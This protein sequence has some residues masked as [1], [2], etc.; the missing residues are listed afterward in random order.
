MESYSLFTDYDI[1]LFKEGNHFRGYTKF[2][3][4][5]LTV[6]GVS[7]VQFAVWA[8]N[9]REVSVIGNFNGW[10]AHSH[11]LIRRKDDS[12]IWEG[13][14]PGIEAGEIYKYHISSNLNGYEVDKGDP[15]AFAWEHPPKTASKVWNL[16]YEWQ[17]KKWMKNRIKTQSLASPMSIYE[18][19]LG[20]WRHHDNEPG[21]S[22]SY[23]ETAIQLAEYVKELGFTHVEFLPIM[24]YPFYG[25]WGYQTTGYF[26]PT[27]R[28]G[29]PQDFMYLV[30]YLHQQGIGV[31]LDWVPSHFPSD[32]HSL[33]YFDGTHLY[34]HAD[35]RKGFHPDW[36]TY[37]YNYGRNE[38]VNFLI[39]SAM[40]WL[41]K[42]HIDGL[43]VDAVASMLYLD[44][45]RKEGEWIPNQY[46]GKEN[47]E[48]IKFIRRFNEVI[49]TEFPDVQTIAEESTSWPMVSRPVS[50]GGLGFGM[51]W[52][53]GWMHDTTSYMSKE[54]VHRKY[55]QHQ[56]TFSML[57]AFHENF[58][59]PLSHDEVVH[60]KG[61]L[62]QKIPG[63]DWQKFANL[64][65]F[66]GYIYT[67]PG[68]KLFFMGNEFGQWNEWCH[69][70]SLDWHLLK[71]LPHAGVK[72]W[73][74]DLNTYYRATPALHERD[75]EPGGFQWIDCNDA[76]NSLL[77][78][79]RYGLKDSELI[80]VACNFTPV[81][82]EGRRFGVPS[83]GIWREELN[84]DSEIYGGSGKG[85]L[86]SVKAEPIP[87]HNMEHSISITMP[88]LGIVMFKQKK[89]KKR[90]AK[91]KKS[92]TVQG[93]KPKTE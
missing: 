29:I 26:A 32:E 31:I 53:M 2:G 19:H 5:P 64:R 63:D 35:P 58:V 3:S 44:Y 68:K 74:S 30:D 13:F 8:P 40:F 6:E 50:M 75:F 77:C 87:S 92:V 37:I 73:M 21:H 24:E 14:V 61:A 34:E 41:E 12:G 49:Y 18:V 72:K 33:A 89:V 46:G 51:K 60:G 38:V 67:H 27:S 20:S 80:F 55:H 65:C 16:D 78:F 42:Y 86:G 81:V 39:S 47:I 70:K 83:A 79:I 66:L 88:P 1:H 43:R 25:S 54:P 84:S 85:N 93:N 17:D 57:Y 11:I 22:L 45:S 36:A 23:R 59:L 52:N 56:L 91:R 76:E 10:N 90:P 28:F 48:A 15:Y 4:H 62:L 69:D 82:R 71:H 9:A 7:G